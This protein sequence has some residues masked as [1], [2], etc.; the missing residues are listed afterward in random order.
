MGD[1][2]RV[3]VCA[4]AQWFSPVS[5]A[6]T[7]LAGTPRSLRAAFYPLVPSPE[8]IGLPLWSSGILSAKGLKTLWQKGIW[9]M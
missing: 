3:C 8:L 6:P 2:V 4:R 1:C 7:D 5:A 9:Q